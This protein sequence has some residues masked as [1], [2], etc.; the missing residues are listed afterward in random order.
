M[1]NNASYYGGFSPGAGLFAVDG[2]FTSCDPCGMPVISFPMKGDSILSKNDLVVFYP[3]IPTYSTCSLGTYPN[4]HPWN[5]NQQVMVLEQEFMVAQ[6]AYF[7]MPLNTPYDVA[8]S[9]GFQDQFP[10]GYPSAEIGNMYLVEEGE[11]Q[12]VGGGIS[13]L[14]RKWSTLP[15]TRCEMEQYAYTFIGLDS[16]TGL[17]RNQTTYNVQSRIQYDYFIFDALDILTIPLFTDG[18]YRLNGTTGLY[19]NGMILPVMQYFAEGS[20]FSFEFG[21]Y[22][23]SP[24]TQLT[25]K[26]LANPDSQATLPTATDY[27]N[28]CTG[29]GTGNG[30]PA[31]IIVESSTMCRWMGNIWERRTRFV[32]A[33]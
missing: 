8:W 9:L 29:Q 32:L 26:N 19:P 15:P 1:P 25:D 16:I 4:I 21:I 28:W 33:Q 10:S 5:P 12:D 18:G 22:V 2:D 27:L 6:N 17:Q 30:Q 7:P 31:E 13:K 20:Q 23:G 11:L 24:T 14:R 3:E